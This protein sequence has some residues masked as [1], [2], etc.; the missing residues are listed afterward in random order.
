MAESH[1][2]EMFPGFV[3]LISTHFA[4]GISSPWGLVD[5][6]TTAMC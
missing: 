6:C 2:S 1:C 3:Q 5:V 4:F